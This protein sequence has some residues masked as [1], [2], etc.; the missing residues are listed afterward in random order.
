M[1]FMPKRVHNL[2][3]WE[4]TDEYMKYHA[5]CYQK[6]NVISVS[7]ENELLL[8][9]AVLDYDDDESRF[10]ALRRLVKLKHQTIGNYNSMS[11]MIKKSVLTHKPKYPSPPNGRFIDMGN[12]LW[13]Q[14]KKKEK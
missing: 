1:S 10:S 9:G 11:V 13:M 14:T 6:K 8:V 7:M 12:H 3:S 4:H 5:D 2:K